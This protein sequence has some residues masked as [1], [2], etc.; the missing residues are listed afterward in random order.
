MRQRVF[1]LCVVL[2][3]SWTGITADSTAANT[4]N[5]WCKTK[6]QD[7]YLS[8]DKFWEMPDDKRQCKAGQMLNAEKKCVDC[9]VGTYNFEDARVDACF[10][11][12]FG[13]FGNVTG[14]TA[15]HDC[16]SWGEGRRGAYITKQHGSTSV[17][18]CIRPEPRVG[19]FTRAT[20]GAHVKVKGKDF[21]TNIK[22]ALWGMSR[23]I[24][25][26]GHF[27]KCNHS[28]K[29]GEAPEFTAMSF[30]LT[31]PRIFAWEVWNVMDMVNTHRAVANSYV[32]MGR[33]F[34]DR[35]RKFV[36]DHSDMKMF[37]LDLKTDML[38]I[39]D[40]ELLEFE[41]YFKGHC[42][43]P[44][45]K[46][47]YCDDVKADVAPATQRYYI[48]YTVPTTVDCKSNAGYTRVRNAIEHS[49]KRGLACL[50]RA[51]DR[52]QME[53][54]SCEG[55]NVIAALVNTALKTEN[56]VA[57]TDADKAASFADDDIQFSKV[58]VFKACDKATIKITEDSKVVCGNCSP[59]QFINNIGMCQLCP[60]GTWGDD[61]VHCNACNWNYTTPWWGMNSSKACLKTDNS[62]SG[63]E[64][65]RN[66]P[67]LKGE[68]NVTL[69]ITPEMNMCGVA[70]A[71]KAVK[72]V[73][74]STFNDAELVWNDSLDFEK[75]KIERI[76]CMGAHSI[77]KGFSEICK[78]NWNK[79]WDIIFNRLQ[80]D[81]EDGDNWI[82]VLCYIF[83]KV[84]DLDEADTS[85]NCKN[86]DVSKY[87]MSMPAR[88][89]FSLDAKGSAILVPIMTR[90]R[91]LESMNFASFAEAEKA[92]MTAMGIQDVSAFTGWKVANKLK[93]LGLEVPRGFKMAKFQFDSKFRKS[94]HICANGEPKRKCNPYCNQWNCKT[95]EADKYKK[96]MCHHDECNNCATQ[97]FWKD[98]ETHKS[99][100]CAKCDFPK[101]VEKGDLVKVNDDNVGAH[102]RCNDG[103]VSLNCTSM[104]KCDY[105][106]SPKKIHFPKCV[107]DRC[108]WPTV[109]NAK[110]WRDWKDYNDWNTCPYTMYKCDD[111]W[112]AAH[113]NRR[114]DCRPGD[115]FKIYTRMKCIKACSFPDRIAHGKKID[116]GRDN[117]HDYYAKYQCEDGYVLRGSELAKCATEESDGKQFAVARMPNCTQKDT[118]SFPNNIGKACKVD[119]WF[120]EKRG[121]KGARYE[122]PEG[123]DREGSNYFRCKKDAPSEV[124]MHDFKCV[125]RTKCEFPSAIDGGRLIEKHDHYAKYQCNEGYRMEGSEW[126]KCNQTSGQIYLPKCVG[127]DGKC[128]LPDMIFAGFKMSEGVHNGEK[129]AVY[130][131]LPPFVMTPNKDAFMGLMK[132]GKSAQEAYKEMAYIGACYKGK[133]MVPSCHEPMKV[134]HCGIPNYIENGK[135]VEFYMMKDHGK[136]DKEKNEEGHKKEDEEYKKLDEDFKKMLKMM[137]MG[138]RYECKEGFKMHKTLKGDWGWC[139][140][141][142]S[143]EVPRCEPEKTWS[144]VEFKLHNG[145]ERRFVN[146]GKVFAGMVLA[147]NRTKSG[148]QGNWEFG[149]N[150]GFNHQAAGAICRTLGWM[151]GVQT[152]LTK[153]MQYMSS[154]EGKP[155]FGWT[156][157]HCRSDVALPSSASCKAKRYEIAMREMGMKAKCFD[158][159]RI[160][161]KCFNNPMFNVTVSLFHSNT[162][163]SCRAL[164][165]KERHLVNLSQMGGVKTRFLMD[166]KDIPGV[167]KYKVK[168]GY[169]MR[170]HLKKKQFKCLSC[171]V[172]A[173]P[174]ML[175]KAEK[176]KDDGKN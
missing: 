85:G 134:K 69:G 133:A 175:G 39:D 172:H 14:M 118:C 167:H 174:I 45:D 113:H 124:H 122:C 109:E 33:H 151:H 104:A 108:Q 21:C 81:A 102:Y 10:P 77:K 95:N 4:E 2:L 80:D 17:K 31:L 169:F 86:L 56:A 148:P 41:P 78:D 110:K 18:Q 1:L 166:N 67:D 35:I 70:Q 161:V 26:D 150:D 129:Y 147:R 138:A 156:G 48:K 76:I 128:H 40:L 121:E 9:P 92:M 7:N 58:T 97:W 103:H 114:V 99:F 53:L 162:K 13:S 30:E 123:T 64:K 145:N 27:Y 170:V 60:F 82:D 119:E 111:G 16:E 8:S 65:K 90:L 75:L 72:E 115:N 106:S 125:E 3:V 44:G 157:F 52:C 42:R 101:T 22:K 71:L 20:V 117:R 176:C 11:C 88:F 107:E 149:C 62:A 55:G 171:E 160:A 51:T 34:V 168:R 59:G 49:E 50:T 6:Q 37:G 79:S 141:D 146:K 126:A 98:G 173:G 32:A 36:R 12:P 68:T 154:T 47:A 164:A 54:V 25:F 105:N 163:I 84:K 142:G 29:N 89:N 23:V 96:K 61:G 73:C 112:M 130:G 137:P 158:F 132:E 94:D 165:M 57:S 83:K 135:A 116:S 15:C 43:N 74:R 28:P 153:K 46:T 66:L 155:K 143:F 144:E 91:N 87:M 140:H 159:D 93:D 131:C 5:G 127:G 38:K 63:N 19:N 100:Q 152:P 139:L 24:P 136:G 120:D